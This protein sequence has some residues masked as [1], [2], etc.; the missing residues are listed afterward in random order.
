MR[1]TSKVTSSRNLRFGKGGTDHMVKPQAAGK[2]A[3][4]RTG[5]IETPAPGAKAARGGGHAPVPGRSLP[6]RGGRTGPR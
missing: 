6:A 1:G 3:S 4:G 5:K 2:A